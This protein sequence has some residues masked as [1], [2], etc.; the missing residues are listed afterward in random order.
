MAIQPN[1]DPIDEFSTIGPDATAAFE[2][3]GA[4][5][6]PTEH[7]SSENLEVAGRKS[8]LDEEEEVEDDDE[9]EADDDRRRGRPRRRRRG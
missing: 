9:V 6:N 2:P 4:P 5:A 8:A 7:A 3:A 1:Q